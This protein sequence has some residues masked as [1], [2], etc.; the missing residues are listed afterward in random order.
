MK[1]VLYSSQTRQRHN[2]KEN[3]RPISSMNVDAKI[4][5]KHWQTEFN[6]ISVRSYTMIKLASSQGCRD[7]S[8]F[9]HH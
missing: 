5:A 3:Y 2:K 6:S 8:T 7:S 1:P 9:A 4:L